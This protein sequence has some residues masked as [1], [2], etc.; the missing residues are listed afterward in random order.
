[1]STTA[2]SEFI[3]GHSVDDAAERRAELRKIGWAL[4]AA[5]LLHLL[6]GTL[7]AAFHDKLFTRV[8]PVEEP[9]RLDDREI[10]KRELGFAARA[11]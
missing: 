9:D 2:P 1:M 10:G 3:I 8:E 6:V 4:L 11:P 7:I 5:L